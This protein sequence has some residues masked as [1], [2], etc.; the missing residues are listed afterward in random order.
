MEPSSW[1]AHSSSMARSF[2]PLAGG[3][4]NVLAS[5]V[6]TAW[7]ISSIQV[8]DGLE[9]LVGL[10]LLGAT[11]AATTAIA[12]GGGSDPAWA[13]QAW[14]AT[15]GVTCAGAAVLGLVV[16]AE[17]GVGPAVGAMAAIAWFAAW[18]SLAGVGSGFFVGLAINGMRGRRSRGGATLDL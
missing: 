11:C 9:L 8:D 12:V 2:H 6:V 3:L 1:S 16:A 5:I 17:A 4:C 15:V 13:V 14:C 7:W 10:P 18:F